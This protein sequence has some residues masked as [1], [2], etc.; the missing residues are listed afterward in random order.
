MN[1]AFLSRSLAIA[2]LSLVAALALAQASGAGR[3]GD[4]LA[5]KGFNV[6]GRVGVQNYEEQ[7]GKL[8]KIAP[9]AS[10]AQSAQTSAK[11][12]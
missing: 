9:K 6:V 7:G 10:A 5:A 12:Q 3:A 8:S 2:A 11:A 4:L 1:L